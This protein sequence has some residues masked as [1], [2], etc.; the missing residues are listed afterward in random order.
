M[1][2]STKFLTEMS[3]RDKVFLLT[4]LIYWLLALLWQREPS[5]PFLVGGVVGFI[6]LPLFRQVV[7]ETGKSVV[8]S[9]LF[10]VPLAILSFYAVS[11]LTSKFGQGFILTLFLQT[12][13]TQAEQTRTAGDIRPWFWP[14]KSGVTLFTTKIYFLLMIV[15]FLYNSS[16]LR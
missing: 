13:L 5:F 3:R 11:A 14:V 2:L 9:I 8:E 1:K 7:G 12:L 15:V 10:Q 6:F 16:L 4:T